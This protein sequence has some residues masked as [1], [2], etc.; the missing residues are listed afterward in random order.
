MSPWYLQF[1][2][3]MLDNSMFPL[4]YLPLLTHMHVMIEQRVVC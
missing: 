2:Y 3:F 1:L 4:N